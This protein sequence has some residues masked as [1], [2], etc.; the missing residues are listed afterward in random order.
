MAPLKVSL[1][2]YGA[3]NVRS[4]RN[5]ILALG[6][7]LVDVDHPD[8]LKDAEVVIFPGV[9]SFGSC[10]SF[11]EA[12]GFVEPLRAYVR[13]GRPYL[14]IC[15]G[16]Q[17][18]F[19]GSDESPGVA[20]LGALPGIVRLF[21]VAGFG[22][23]VPQIG[24]NGIAPY[25]ASAALE[26]I[27]EDD[28]VYFVHSFHVPLSPELHDWVLTTTTY[29]ENYVSSV[30]RG[31]VMAT[32]F[33]PE[34]SAK[35]GLRVLQNFLEAIGAGKSLSPSEAP[36]PPASIAKTTAHRRVVACLDVRSNDDGDLVVTKGDSYNVRE[37]PTEGDNGAKRRKGVVRNLG[38][39]VALAS[40]YFTEGAD[41]ITFLNI[42]GFRDCP[43]QDLPMLELLAEASQTMFVPL[44]VGGGIRDFTDSTGKTHTALEVASAYF[45]AGADKVSIGSEVR[46]VAWCGG[47]RPRRLTPC[48][49]RG[50]AARDERL[51]P[52]A[53]HAAIAFIARGHKCAGDTCI[54]AIAH[55]YGRQAVVISVDPR[56]VWVETSSSAGVHEAALLRE[57]CGAKGPNGESLCWYECTVKGGREGS[58]L[59]V[60]Q[61]V[62]ACEALG[63]GEILLNSID[64]DGKN[65]GFDIDLVAQVKGAVSIP[66]IASSGAGKAEHFKEVFEKTGVEVRRGCP[67]PARHP[68]RTPRTGAHQLRLA[69]PP[70]PMRRRRSPL[71]S[72]TGK[73]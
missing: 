31:K 60:V 23:S 63:A 4:V 21:D 61:L 67:R 10:M 33:H 34:K 66:V 38:K 62:T 26:G 71:A 11:L 44:C 43:L 29:G 56:R 15:L 13:A 32:Q 49:A 18:L 22:L 2:D 19:E 73:R 24:W 72:S 30:L 68:A 17:T 5:A 69:G 64:A 51:C 48:A 41:E 59:D 12:K 55:V 47:R 28:S 42:T 35:V 20:G 37:V 8:Q 45:R 58:D 39:P 54:E 53:V 50:P 25:K 16:M 46:E 9:G 1:L 14:G 7:D 65:S 6:Y 70:F 36:V 27:G 52:Q 40:R 3:G 57:P